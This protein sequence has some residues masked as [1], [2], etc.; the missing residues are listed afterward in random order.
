MVGT[1]T[2]VLSTVGEF[3][4]CQ[5]FLID[6][7]TGEP[8]FAGGDG[9]GR[10]QLAAMQENR[11]RGAPMVI[12]QAFEENRV[13]VQREWLRHVRQEPR[14]APIRRFVETRPDPRWAFLAV[15]M[16][17]SGTRIGVLT[18]GIP[19]PAVITPDTVRRWCEL[20][21]QTA[22]ALRYADALRGAHV[23]GGDHERQ[24]L[25][26]DLHDTVGQDVFALKMLAARAEAVAD[27]DMAGHV[28][29]LRAL[30]DRVDSGVRALIGE[31]RQVGPAMPLSG[32]LAGI[33]GEVGA[34]SGVDIQVLIS[35]EWDHLS[36]ECAETVIRIV[37]EALHNIEKHAQ[38]RTAT[39]RLTVGSDSM[40]LIEV[41]DDGARLDP[42][43]VSPASFGL[44]FIRERAAEY[45]GSVDVRSDPRTTLRV[46]LRPAFESAWD[47]VIH[48]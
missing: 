43:A 25:N 8:V 11:R 12:W 24:R 39:L 9:L 10:E 33:A 27:P 40:L 31:R 42:D 17:F 21:D 44:N 45:G 46:R 22:L 5:I 2:Q 15:P 37:Q 47:A 19:D 23:A 16:R 4:G 29:E 32:Q 26:E 41:S 34:R 35:G 1:L 38:A 28:R 18:G 36:S 30:A 7:Q 6:E 13:V 20:A 3:E 48:G 14:L